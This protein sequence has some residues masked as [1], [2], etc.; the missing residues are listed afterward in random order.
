M[1]EDITGIDAI[2]PVGDDRA[3]C[4]GH[5]ERDLV[6]GNGL[7]VCRGDRARVTA[8]KDVDLVIGDEFGCGFLAS[9]CG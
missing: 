1:V 2:R 7:L 5:N 8:D 3:R 9:R 4:T 6:V